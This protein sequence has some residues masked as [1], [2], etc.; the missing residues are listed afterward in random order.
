LDAFSGSGNR[1]RVDS[2]LENRV[3]VM[4]ISTDSF[5]ERDVIYRISST[6]ADQTDSA[7]SEL[8]PLYETIDPDALD[9]FLG[10]SDDNAASASSVEFSYCGHRLRVDSTG[11][12]QLR[13]EPEAAAPLQSP[14]D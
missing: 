1:N 11:Q 5:E 12:V 13:P 7:L 14:M 3:A 10:S 9:A 4:A 2:H 6:I 8:P